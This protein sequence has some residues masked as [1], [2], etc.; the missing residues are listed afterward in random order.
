MRRIAE[1][2]FTSGHTPEELPFEDKRKLLKLI[3]G[4][5]DEDGARYVI[6]VTCLGGKPKKFKFEAYGRL[7]NLDGWVETGNDRVSSFADAKIDT[8]ANSEVVESI[9]S[10]F[11]IHKTRESIKEGMRCERHAHN[12]LRLRQ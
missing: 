7:G 4:G 9:A 6:F 5:R 3:L 2:H 11:P 1:S 8:Q 12:G 10:F